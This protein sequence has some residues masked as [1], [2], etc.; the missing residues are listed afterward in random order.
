LKPLKKIGLLG[1]SHSV[2]MLDSM[3]KD[4]RDQLPSQ[5]K[6]PDE[7]YPETHQ[8][9]FTTDTKDFVVDIPSQKLNEKF[10][11]EDTD[12]SL[13]PIYGATAGGNLTTCTLDA[14]GNKQMFLT[15]VYNSYLKKFKDYDY[16]I[17]TIF[18]ND[19]AF[20]AYVDNLPGYDFLEL[21][22]ENPNPLEKQFRPIDQYDITKFMTGYTDNI[23]H[24]LYCAT[25]M[26][27]NLKIIHLLPPPP[28]KK[29][30][31]TIFKEILQPLL[32]EHGIL[33]PSLR[34]KLYNSYC[35]ILSKKL[36]EFGVKVLPPPPESFTK[37]G[38]KKMSFT[39]GLTHGNAKY[40][41]LCWR[42]IFKEI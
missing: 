40:G 9:W 35:W 24:A 37:D 6:S 18:G 27:P 38:Y 12:L 41:E 16:M 8:N 11:V 25:S 33:R 39:D 1:H 10:A 19:H 42:Q 5:E 2:C 20:L 17:S 3:D 28:L 36:T 31:T 15:E 30:D 23:V 29:P 32:E 4:W 34:L 22:N 14:A 7:R 21:G 13:Y 26:N